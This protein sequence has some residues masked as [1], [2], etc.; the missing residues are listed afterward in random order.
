MFHEEKYFSV[1]N[2]VI[3]AIF[4]HKFLGINFCN[5]NKKQNSLF[6]PTVGEHE[7]VS[8]LSTSLRKCIN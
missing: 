5:S 8:I 3:K 2:S 6:C 1:I 4:T 7:I